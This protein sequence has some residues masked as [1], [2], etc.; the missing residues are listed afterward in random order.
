MIQSAPVSIDYCARE[1]EEYEGF[2]R[3]KHHYF[4]LNRITREEF[5]ELSLGDQV[6]SLDR[7]TFLSYHSPLFP[8]FLF[9][10][11]PHS[12]LLYS[13]YF[14]QKDNEPRRIKTNNTEDAVRTRWQTQCGL[15]TVD[16]KSQCQGRRAQAQ[17][18]IE[19]F[20]HT[21]KYVGN[22]SQLCIGEKDAI[23]HMPLKSYFIMYIYEQ[24]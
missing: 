22:G 5:F 1:R 8:S 11:L 24:T 14:I 10:S 20:Q 9:H 4:Y 16:C 19:V 21:S 13:I 17:I 7:I 15:K 23:D 3:E 18:V 12:F 2:Q 6:K